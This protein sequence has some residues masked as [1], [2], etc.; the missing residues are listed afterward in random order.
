MRIQTVFMAVALTSALATSACSSCKRQ[1]P[2][3]PQTQPVGSD[4]TPTPARDPEAPPAYAIG[5]DLNTQVPMNTRPLQPSDL[6][7]PLVQEWTTLRGNAAR[8]GVRDVPAVANPRILWRTEVGIGGY[9]NTIVEGGDLIWVSTQG[10]E[11]DQSDPQDGVVAIRKADGQIAW[12]YRTGKDANGMTL[13][14][15]TLYVVT[16]DHMLHAIRA[17]DGSAIWVRDLGCELY[18]APIVEGE[19]LL[20][21]RGGKVERY[22]RSNGQPELTPTRCSDGER[23]G[24][25]QDGGT[26]VSASAVGRTRLFQDTTRVWT[27][28]LPDGASTTLISWL[29]PVLLS[30]LVV[31]LVHAWPHPTD[32]I[33]HRDRPI[34][35]RRA[36]LIARWRDSGEIA[37]LF[38]INGL[39][40]EGTNRA[41]RLYTVG[42]PLVVGGRAYI[43]SQ[44]R[45]EIAV[46]NLLTGERE[47]SIAVSDCRVRQFS[48]MVG[49][50]T[51]GYIARHDGVLSQFSYASQALTWSIS[52]GKASLSGATRSHALARQGRCTPEPIDGTALFATPTIG[53]DGTVYV[54]SGEGWVYAIGDRP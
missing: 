15:G 12:R 7:L 9:A 3:P 27:E 11:H 28:V 5:D 20:I 50:T 16:D 19:Y 8:S 21:E 33:D 44:L 25:S 49:T 18:N 51:H 37:W 48:S 30:N 40:E 14:D 1:D 45:P 53:S 6:E 41:M 29:P 42:L 54:L 31:T 24:L 17:D 52:L 26:V 47:G 2:A 23:A 36:A 39:D 38:D 13:A 35:Q 4:E 10:S 32:E 34:F 43:A 22:F 46:V